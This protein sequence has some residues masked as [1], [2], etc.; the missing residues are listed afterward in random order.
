VAA[1]S[2]GGKEEGGRETREVERIR[3]RGRGRRRRLGPYPLAQ[4]IGGGEDLLGESTMASA[5]QSC[6]TVL[7]NTKEILQKCPPGFWDF[8]EILKT[9]HNWQ[10]LLI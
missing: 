10:Y 5:P 6:F 8:L 2:R 3:E 4:S 1:S 7:R 9:A